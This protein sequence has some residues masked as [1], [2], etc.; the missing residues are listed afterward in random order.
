[1]RTVRVRETVVAV[2]RAVEARAVAGAV[3]GAAALDDV[4][5][6]A[7]KADLALTAKGE[8]AHRSRPRCTDAVPR[9]ILAARRVHLVAARAAEA[10]VA[11]ALA[12]DTR[13]VAAAVGGAERKRRDEAAVVAGEAGLAEAVAVAQALA[14]ASAVAGAAADDSGAVVCA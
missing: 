4:A 11:A 14:V 7:A 12:V 9:A 10:G 1:M 3:A 13:S 8:G 2:T 5:R 6:G